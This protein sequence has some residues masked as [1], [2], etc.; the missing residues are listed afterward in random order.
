MTFTGTDGSVWDLRSIPADGNAV[1][2][3][4]QGLQG[5]RAPDFTFFTRAGAFTD[6]QTLTGFQTQPRKVFLPLLIGVNLDPMTFLDLS[7]RWIAAN[8]IGEYATLRV[9]RPDGEWR[10][11]R[12]RFNDDGGSQLTDDPVEEGSELAGWTYYADDP[13]WYGPERRFPF[14]SDAGRDFFNDGAAPPFYISSSFSM[15]TATID[16]SGDV[17]AWL[18]YTLWGPFDNWTFGLADGTIGSLPMADG[19][20]IDVFTDPSAQYITR[21][22]D[23][24]EQDITP[25]VP[26]IDWRPAPRGQAVP[27]QITYQ[28]TGHLEA[29]FRPRFFRGY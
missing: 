29:R 4:N 10:E 14:G 15:R 23:G 5:L 9:T 24:N 6:G 28:G 11:I 7:D 12:I 21:T 22:R 8:T 2:L 25:L 18:R 1:Y 26:S 27:L 19:D 17:P 13:Y 3:T 20:R 16:N